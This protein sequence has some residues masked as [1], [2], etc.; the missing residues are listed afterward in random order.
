MDSQNDVGNSRP[1]GEFIRNVNV[2]KRNFAAQWFFKTRTRDSFLKEVTEKNSSPHKVLPGRG[3]R[4]Q[5]KQ[6]SLSS[7]ALWR[8]ANRFARHMACLEIRTRFRGRLE[9]K[10]RTV[11]GWLRYK[12]LIKREKSWSPEKAER[13]V[14]RIRPHEQRRWPVNQ[15]W[16]NRSPG[17]GS[18]CRPSLSKTWRAFRYRWGCPDFPDAWQEVVAIRKVFEKSTSLIHGH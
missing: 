14:S 2:L 7:G 13:E 10:L 3:I 4:R 11:R 5:H 8:R 18:G 6:A 9:P 16:W 17:H 12:K 15:S 1:S